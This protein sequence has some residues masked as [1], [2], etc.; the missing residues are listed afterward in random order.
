MR[1]KRWREPSAHGRRGAANPI[2]V[3]GGAPSAAGAWC[4]MPDPEAAERG[5]WHDGSMPTEIRLVPPT[6]AGHAAFIDC[7]ADFAGS[8]EDEL[9][10]AGIAPGGDLPAGDGA[11]I[12]YVTD[13]LAAEGRGQCSS[14]WIV[15]GGAVSAG[16]EHDPGGGKPREGDQI[17]GFLAI[18][19]RLNRYL[20]E[21]GGHIGYSVRP[22]ARG[23]GIATAALE[24]ALVE[25]RE[26]GIERVLV[27]CDEDNAASRRVIEKAGGHVEDV[28][29]NRRRYWFGGQP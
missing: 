16:E 20:L 12:D 27:T 24:Q 13:R 5:G 26:L 8:G 18:R 11:F 21:L 22:S 3:R 19:H 23:R 4:S 10:C 29:E 15:S 17:L 25:A 14:R 2:R 28:R 6:S 1:P 7:L 9:D